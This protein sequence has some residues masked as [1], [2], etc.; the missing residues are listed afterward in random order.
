LS[1]DANRVETAARSL[2]VSAAEMWLVHAIERARVRFL[3]AR[4]FG[5]FRNMVTAELA[6]QSAAASFSEAMTRGGTVPETAEGI[7]RALRDCVD[8][9]YQEW[10]EQ[11]PQPPRPRS[12]PTWI[13]LNLHIKPGRL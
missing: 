1:F 7:G 5:D 11:T 13:A 10:L 12:W 9:A 6:C 3:H 2:G 4:A 8:E